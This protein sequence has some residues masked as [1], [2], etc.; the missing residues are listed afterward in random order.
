MTQKPGLS[1]RFERVLA[2]LE[3]LILDAPDNEIAPLESRASSFSAD[4]GGIV[5]HH[6]RSIGAEGHAGR[7]IKTF[8]LSSGKQIQGDAESEAARLMLLRRL[9]TARPKLPT[10]LSA[11]FEGREIPTSRQLNEL[12]EEL[13]RLG[14]LSKD[15]SESR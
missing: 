7:D 12:T 9:V 15:D 3:D 2:E 10:H 11:V 1:E 4:I 6:L 13:R 14:L 5:G 8:R